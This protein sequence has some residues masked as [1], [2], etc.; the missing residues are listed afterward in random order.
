MEPLAMTTRLRLAALLVCLGLGVAASLPT[1][2]VAA[3]PVLAAVLKEPKPEEFEGAR[4]DAFALSPDAKILVYTLRLPHPRRPRPGDEFRPFEGTAFVCEVATGK[5]LFRLP[6]PPETTITSFSFTPDSARLAVG[7]QGGLSVWDLT[8][9][10]KILETPTPGPPVFSGDGNKL[11][12]WGVSDVAPSVAVWD[13]PT[14]KKAVE[15]IDPAARATMTFSPDAKALIGMHTTRVPD[16]VIWVMDLETGKLKSTHPME[17][18]DNEVNRVTFSA[19][20]KTAATE[21]INP[22]FNTTGKQFY[23]I[24]VHLWD[25][26]SGKDLGQLGEATG[27]GSRGVAHGEKSRQFGVQANGFHV[28]TSP[29]GM[30]FAAPPYCQAPRTATRSDFRELSEAQKGELREKYLPLSKFNATVDWAG[31][32]P[33]GNLIVVIGQYTKRHPFETPALLTLDVSKTGEQ[34]A[35]EL[36]AKEIEERWANLSS[37]DASTAH[38]AVVK[39]AKFP[40]QT[41]AFLKERVN[42]VPKADPRR[43]AQCIAD[44]GDDADAVREKAEAELI[45]RGKEAVSPVRRAL[46]E[47]PAPEMRKRLERIH[48][49]IGLPGLPLATRRG[50][51]TIELLEQIGTPEARDLLKTLAK[52]EADAW[53]TREA[54][55][56]LAD[57][58]SK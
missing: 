10:K 57:A 39:L 36:T 58:A 37:E 31:L 35:T 43:V 13:L 56:A 12:V 5:E 30:L 27:A 42:P 54:K 28:R 14:G 48:D 9:G 3:E 32:S 46:V 44:L 7:R 29:D 22:G 2:A 15:L 19:D 6:G 55:A 50:L 38:A 11:A 16:M 47:S 1:G 17:I 24:T 21:Y 18:P 8:T 4:V 51:W 34:A 25:I 20:A 33:D 45:E 41:L 49:R 53:V 52:G 23:T 26:A 40:K